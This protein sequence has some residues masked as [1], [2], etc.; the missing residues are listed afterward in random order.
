[1]GLRTHLAEPAS[2]LPKPNGRGQVFPVTA[3][4]GWCEVQLGPAAPARS[5]EHCPGWVTL[6]WFRGLGQ[7]P[8]AAL[9]AWARHCC[10]R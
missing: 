5:G 8:A 7:A 3:R 4:K 1:M 2:K 6:P 10:P 9:V